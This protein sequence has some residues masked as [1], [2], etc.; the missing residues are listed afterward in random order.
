[1]KEHRKRGLESR[2]SRLRKL[3]YFLPLAFLAGAAF[4]GAAFLPAGAS[5]FFAVVFLPEKAASQPEANLGFD[6]RR[7]MVTITILSDGRTMCS[8]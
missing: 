7:V 2:L 6:P 5:S 1:M 4:F 3:N 8:K